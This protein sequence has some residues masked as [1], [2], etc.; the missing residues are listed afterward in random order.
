MV[1]LGF[2]MNS[3]AGCMGVS[4]HDL[5]EWCGGLDGVDDAAPPVYRSLALT[6]FG[7]HA[8]VGLFHS[9]IRVV[10][11]SDSV[12]DI[13]GGLSVRALGI[14]GAVSGLGLCLVIPVPMRS[15]P[16]IGGVLPAKSLL[17][18]LLGLPCLP[19]WRYQTRTEEG[20]SAAWDRWVTIDFAPLGVLKRWVWTDPVSSSACAEPGIDQS[21]WWFCLLVVSAF[22][23]RADSRPGTGAGRCGCLWPPWVYGL[24]ADSA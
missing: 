4:S 5:L 8:E 14:A 20:V 1:P 21:F 24:P 13:E 12:V 22:G 10:D 16:F 6:G 9:F 7:N 15:L 23:L 2:H 3:G 19:W 18:V 11:D 17:P